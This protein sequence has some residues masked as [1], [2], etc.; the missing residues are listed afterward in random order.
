MQ[1]TKPQG[2]QNA[3]GKS[4]KLYDYPAAPVQVQALPPVLSHS[5][6]D[7]RENTPYNNHAG[8]S[9]K[10]FSRDRSCF[11]YH[12]RSHRITDPALLSFMNSHTVY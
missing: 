10:M 2:N 1:E 3:K 5:E 6:L 9:G 12:I 4:W 11:R 7:P 8:V